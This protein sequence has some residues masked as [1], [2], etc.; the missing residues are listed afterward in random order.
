MDLT[1]NR[2]SVKEIKKLA[3]QNNAPILEILNS[4]LDFGIFLSKVREK[5][6]PNQR[7]FIGDPKEGMDEMIEVT[8]L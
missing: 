1:L 8:G 5:K 3:K 4:L 7:I 6:G 2:K